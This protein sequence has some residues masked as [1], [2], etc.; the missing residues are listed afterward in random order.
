MSVTG[1]GGF[2][3]L[4]TSALCFYEY[5]ITFSEEVRCVWRRRVSGASVLFLVNRYTMLVVS[6]ASIVQ[7]IPWKVVLPHGVSPD[8]DKPPDDMGIYGTVCT[9]SLRVVDAFLIIGSSA[10][11]VFASLRIF[12][13]YGMRKSIFAA[14]LAVGLFNPGAQIFR[15]I[16]EDANAN[17][18][19]AIAVHNMPLGRL[20]CFHSVR[21]EYRDYHGVDFERI[22]AYVFFA[23]RVHSMIFEGILIG[24]TW[25]KAFTRWS[26]QNTT[27]HT[28]YTTMLLR[29][30]TVYFVL[31]ALASAINLVGAITCPLKL[32]P[33]DK[34]TPIFA[35][36]STSIMVD[37]YVVPHS[38]DPV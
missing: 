7:V 34:D 28:P 37:T 4:A 1:G 14:V 18:S 31:I 17:W 20:N 26:L 10:Y 13:L 19:Y 8:F 38:H 21:E 30:G 22:T 16:I 9:T 25:R 29:D 32:E 36:L 27:V 6:L 2:F 15:M 23:I 35:L 12:A 24:L 33:N 5:M 3:A 11:T